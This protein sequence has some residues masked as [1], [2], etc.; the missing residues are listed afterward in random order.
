[1]RIIKAFPPNYNQIVKAFPF[2][3]GRVGILYAWGDR[4]FNP[5]NIEVPPYLMSHE[6]VHGER[7]LKGRQN[8]IEKWWGQ[9]MEDP[10]FRLK[11]ELLA[12]IAEYEA[13][14]R[15]HSDK[16]TERYLSTIASRLSS[17]LYGNL[18][19]KAQAVTWITRETVE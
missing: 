1:M 8:S 5:S 6:K 10:H 16:D 12:H 15:E 17:S 7:Q 14:H 4:L 3:R 9:Y 2:I 18:C 13:Y 11:E 19:T